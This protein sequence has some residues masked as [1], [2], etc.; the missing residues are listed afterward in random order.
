MINNFKNIYMKYLFVLPYNEIILQ[1]EVSSSPRFTTAEEQDNTSPFILGL[2]LENLTQNVLVMGC[3]WMGR[4]R[5]LVNK[6]DGVAPLITDPP[7]HSFT[8]L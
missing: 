6:L 2:G 1:P 4:V 5:A 3:F 7:L 8:T